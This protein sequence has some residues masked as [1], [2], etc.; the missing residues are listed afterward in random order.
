MRAD[1][2]RQGGE[3]CG[4]FVILKFKRSFGGD[5]RKAAFRKEGQ[6]QESQWARECA[7]LHPHS[8]V[9]AVWR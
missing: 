9:G 1:R 4:V 7:S 2:S 5:T 3:G 6:I 8:A